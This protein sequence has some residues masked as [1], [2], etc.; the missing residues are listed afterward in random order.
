MDCRYFEKDHCQRKP[1]G[2]EK[3]NQCPK[4]MFE[5]YFHSV[6]MF[7]KRGDQHKANFSLANS[8]V[9]SNLA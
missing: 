8:Q 6:G 1:V 9:C 5:G 7:S 4:N 3:N 2:D